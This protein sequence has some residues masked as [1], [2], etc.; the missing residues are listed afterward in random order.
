MSLT[1]RTTYSHWPKQA[2]PGFPQ[3]SVFDNTQCRRIAGLSYVT[4]C[5]ETIISEFPALV[6]S[7][8]DMRRYQLLVEVVCPRRRCIGANDD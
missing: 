6:Q 3:F 4:V 1:G 7:Y 5:D 2:K 8:T